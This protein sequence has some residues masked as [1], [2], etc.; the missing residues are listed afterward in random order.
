MGKKLRDGYYCPNININNQLMVWWQSPEIWCWKEL[1]NWHPA[2]KAGTKLSRCCRNRVSLWNT[3]DLSLGKVS[4]S[5]LTTSS[6]VMSKKLIL[7][8]NIP[9]KAY[10]SALSLCYFWE[11]YRSGRRFIFCLSSAISNDENDVLAFKL[12]RIVWNYL[13]GIQIE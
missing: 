7:A 6:W 5:N 13:C 10:V 3:L 8:A 2:E 12:H 1:C 4:F 11:T 9:N